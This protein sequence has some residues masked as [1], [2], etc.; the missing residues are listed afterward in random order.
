MSGTQQNAPEGNQVRQVQVARASRQS[1]R[2]AGC[3]G[4]AS[5]PRI[6][7]A[8]RALRRLR[9]P[10]YHAAFSVLKGDHV[11]ASGLTYARSRRRYRRRQPDGGADQAAGARDARPGA[12]AEIGGFGGLFDLERAPASRTRCWSRPPT[13]SAPSSRSPSRPAATTPSASTWSPCASTT[14]WCRAPSRCSSSTTSPAGKLR[15]G[16]RRGR[17]RRHRGRLQG[18]PA[19]R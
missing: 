3:P 18:R 7:T 8:I 15:P 14:S 10:R 4:N 1:R 17:G 9:F 19:A 13:A 16:D 5:D 6:I 2:P 12:D 11:R